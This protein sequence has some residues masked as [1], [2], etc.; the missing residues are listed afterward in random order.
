MSGKF[1]ENNSEI[2]EEFLE[3]RR[4]ILSKLLSVRFKKKIHKTHRVKF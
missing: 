2:F 3:N 4:E 1:Q